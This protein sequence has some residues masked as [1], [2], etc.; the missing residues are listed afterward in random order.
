[1]YQIGSTAILGAIQI[2]RDTLGGGGDSQKCHIGGR[3]GLPMCLATFFEDFSDV[4][5]TFFHYYDKNMFI[6]WAH[7]Y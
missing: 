6:S 4:L 1:M 7:V 3:G 2:I 5:K